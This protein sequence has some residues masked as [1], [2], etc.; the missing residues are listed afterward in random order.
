[1]TSLLWPPRLEPGQH[2]LELGGGDQPMLR[3]NLD[4]RRLR[5]VDVAWDLENFPYPLRDGCADLI[6]GKFIAEHLSWKI[7]QAFCDELY[8]LCAP[9]GRVVLVTPNTLAQCRRVA[10]EGEFTQDT[11]CALYGGQG[12]RED[13]H[14]SAW[15]PKLAQARLFQAGFYQ[16]LW[17]PIDFTGAPIADE[18]KTDMVVE[19]R[20]SQVEVRIG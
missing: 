9:G 6:L 16:V 11:E 19:A 18:A 13:R 12:Y 17:E 7:V 20:K 4:S 3:P 5:N 1:M 10:R 8:R 2:P 15:S 14:I